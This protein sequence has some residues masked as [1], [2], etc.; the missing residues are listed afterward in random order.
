M[1]EAQ[2]AHRLL[3]GPKDLVMIEGAN[4][5]DLYDNAPHVATVT[6]AAVDWFTEHL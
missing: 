3:T 1:A 2:Q 6:N 4:H 5:I